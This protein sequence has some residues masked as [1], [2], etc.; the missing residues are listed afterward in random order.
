M[1]ITKVVNEIGCFDLQF[2]RDVKN[3]RANSP[4]Y[5][6]WKAQFVIVAKVDK[7]D[8]LKQICNML[9]CGRIHY[10]TGTRL[11]YSVQDIKSLND[12]IVPFFRTNPLSGNK[13]K[14]FELWAEAIGIIYQNKGKSLNQ[15]PRD[16]FLRLIDIQKLTQQYKTKKTQNSKWLSIA[17]SLYGASKI[18][19][20]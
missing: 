19:Y 16:S 17:E 18:A 4:V 11:R 9:N 3:K 14:D 8:L 20:F 2:R 7:E 15:W 1:N 6:G 13:K 5:Y 10:I 12:V